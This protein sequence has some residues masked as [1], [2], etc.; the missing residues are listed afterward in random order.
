MGGGDGHKTPDGRIFV[1]GHWRDEQSWPVARAVTTSYY[2]HSDGTLSTQRPISSQATSFM[3][4]PRHPVPTLGGNTSSSG[5]LM[6]NG[7][8]D[9]HCRPD[10]WACEG[11]ARPLSARNDVLVFRSA[12]LKQ[13]MEVTGRLIVKLW[14]S[15]SAPDTDFTAKLID[16]YPPN[17]H[18]PGGVDLNIADS[19]IRARYRTS[20]EKS[21]LM[22]PGQVYEFTIEMYPTSLLFKK[23]HRIRVDISSSNFPRF[24]VNPNTGEPLNGNRRWAIA[25]NSI[26]HDPQHPSRIEL[27]VVPA[28]K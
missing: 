18:F 17:D 6:V 27:P 1:G 10:Y 7:A 22:M 19:I 4:D 20:R 23:G 11:D 26:Y 12:P 2:F 24:D 21:E 15:S 9:Q 25:T 16:V 8:L 28:A 14:A 13:D 3:F 5:V